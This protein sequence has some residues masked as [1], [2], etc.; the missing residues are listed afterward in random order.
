MLHVGGSLERLRH[1]LSRQESPTCLK[2]FNSIPPEPVNYSVRVSPLGTT[3]K[4]T[5]D[6]YKRL[7][8]NKK[9]YTNPNYYTQI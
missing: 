7:K 8:C 4:V 2:G 5:I 6:V 9:V 1:G 3:G